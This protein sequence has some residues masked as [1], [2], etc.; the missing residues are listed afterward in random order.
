MEHGA[1]HASAVH[2]DTGLVREVAGCENWKLLPELLSGGFHTRSNRYFT[3]SASGKHVTQVA[4]RSYHLQ[5]I[6]FDLNFILRPVVNNS[7]PAHL[8]L[9]FGVF[10]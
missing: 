6:R 1:S 7:S 10:S 2:M 9:E 5:L 8:K 3:V 4:E